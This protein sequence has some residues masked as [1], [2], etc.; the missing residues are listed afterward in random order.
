MNLSISNLTVSPNS[1]RNLFAVLFLLGAVNGRAAEQATAEMTFESV[2]AGVFDYTIKLND[3][4]TTNIET[5]W[6]SWV[7]GKDFLP[8][9]PTGIVSPT[10]WNA[11]ITHGGSA[12]GFAIQWLTSSSATP[13]PLTPG[14]SLDFSFDSTATPQTLAGDSPFYS[15]TPIGTSFVYS[16]A[17]FSDAGFEFV[18]ESAPE[19]SPA[20]LSAAGLL[21]LL[22]ISFL[23]RKLC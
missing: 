16:G 4:G 10:D 12:D 3:T 17:P 6:F 19:P 8:S 13:A 1:L 20:E 15:T 7:P 5:F 22:G 18:V 11:N 14:S 21:L 9:S 23:Y 2:G